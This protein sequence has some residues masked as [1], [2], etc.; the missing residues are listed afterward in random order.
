MLISEQLAKNEVLVKDNARLQR[1]LTEIQRESLCL[2][3]R[4]SKKSEAFVPCGHVCVCKAC[5]DRLA[6]Q[7]AGSVIC[8]TCRREVCFTMRVYV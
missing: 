5:Y 8:P 6:G 7:R 4:D 1:E 3:C 2:I